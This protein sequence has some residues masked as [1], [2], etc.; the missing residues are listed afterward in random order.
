VND[1]GVPDRCG[2]DSNRADDGILDQA[3]GVCPGWCGGSM[4]QRIIG[5]WLG[6]SAQRDVTCSSAHEAIRE[7]RRPPTSASPA[8]VRIA[9]G[10]VARSAKVRADGLT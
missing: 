4:N 8:T 2:A 3:G 6:R 10:L 9:H 7:C 5:G 1:P